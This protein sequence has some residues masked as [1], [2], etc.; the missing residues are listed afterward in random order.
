MENF[1]KYKSLDPYPEIRPA[2][3]NSSDIFDY[4]NTT[5]MINPFDPKNIKSASYEVEFSGTVYYWDE[6]GEK[7]ETILTDD[8]EYILKKNSIA[9][10]FTKAIFRLP[11]YIALRFNLKITHVHRG[12]LLGTGP[13]ID[14]G[15]E[16]HLLI[17]LHNLTTNDYEIKE[18][19]G[20]IWVEF[21]K[22]SDNKRW[23]NNKSTLP[24]HGQYIP[25]PENKTNLD[26]HYFFKKAAGGRD[27]R[28]SIP[29]AMQK[30]ANDANRAKK[31]AEKLESRAST[32]WLVSIIG[33]ILAFLAI[34]A[35]L[36]FSYYPILQLTQDSVKYIK[37]ET[38]RLEEKNIDLNLKIESL[39]RKLN[40]IVEDSKLGG[41]KI[42]PKE[43]V[44]KESSKHKV[45]DN[46]VKK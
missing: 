27:I 11:D 28:S 25:Y 46:E 13:L 23:L 31:I 6:N 14:P 36:F 21:T 5:G 38:I 29:H 35:G 45:K 22:L 24:Y 16:G 39:Q 26:A 1:D 40:E 37:N 12:L 20:I 19:D 2:L 8:Q 41:K 34:L 32:Q 43:K 42:P 17:P 9:F 15:Y 44:N 33:I 10:L 7:K 4:V 18:G 3:L 30:S